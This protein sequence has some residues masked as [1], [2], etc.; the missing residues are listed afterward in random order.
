MNK[1]NNGDISQ[2]MRR[3]NNKVRLGSIRVVATLLSSVLLFGALVLGVAY[4]FVD[5]IG[6]SVSSN[7]TSV[8]VVS[9]NAS[10]L[11]ARRLPALL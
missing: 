11:N 10:L 1:V 2:S 9:P 5:D 8:Q 4:K 6:T 7:Q 3:A